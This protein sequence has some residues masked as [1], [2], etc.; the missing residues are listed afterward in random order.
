[1]KPGL[2][3]MVALLCLAAGCASNAPEDKET[4]PSTSIAQNAAGQYVIK[5]SEITGDSSISFE[6][7]GGPAILIST[8]GKYYA[9]ADRCTLE[10]CQ[11]RYSDG[12]LTC[13]CC[14]S[15]FDPASG[16]AVSGRAK[17]ALATLKVTVTDGSIY[18]SGP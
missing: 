4:A 15:V 1:M 17:E 11:L 16:Q 10:G 7:N 9:Y 5:E 14:R 2:A 6:Y 18:V 13:P 3:L 8:G 12:K